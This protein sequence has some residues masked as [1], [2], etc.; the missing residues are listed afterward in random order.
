MA[1]RKS[2]LEAMETAFG[3]NAM[4]AGIVTALDAARQAVADAGIGTSNTGRGLAEALERFKTVYFDDSLAAARAL[5]G[6]EDA[7]AALPHFGRGRRG[8]VDAG[9]GLAAAAR[10]FLD[11]VDANIGANSQS[12]DAKHG[13]V[14]AS[15]TQIDLS[16]A[17]IETDLVAMATIDAEQANA[18]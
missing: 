11:T 12:L 16:L 14:A 7:V 6:E 15:L 17:A 13:A 4:R 2:W 18:A 5:A 10:A 1:V 8:A 9:N 3:P